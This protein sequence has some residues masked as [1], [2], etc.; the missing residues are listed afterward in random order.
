M[1]GRLLPV[2]ALLLFGAAVLLAVA[3]GGTTDES[4]LG[5]SATVYDEGP[6]GTALLRRYLEANGL[7]T[8]TLQSDRFVVPAEVDV[9]FLLGVTTDIPPQDI[10]T[11]REF[12]E[13]GGTLVIASDLAQTERPLLAA[14]DVRRAGGSAPPGEH[15]IHSIVFAA[16]VVRRLY[17]DVAGIVL[18]PGA[19]GAVLAG[20]PRA[21]L[22]V[23]VG[24]GRGRMYAVGSLAPFLNG[25]LPQ[26]DNGRLALS[27]AGITAG[28]RLVAFDEFHHGRRA[29]PSFA[30]VLTGSWP[31][32]A[33]LL[34]GA[35]AFA[36]LA[37]SGRRLGP[38]LPLD[39]RPPRSSLDYVRGFAGL[40]RRSGHGEIARRRIRSDLHQGLARRLGMD[41][42]TPFERVVAMLA[43]REPARA[44]RARS[45][46]IAL[47]RRMA[48]AE[49]VRSVGEVEDVVRGEP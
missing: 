36:Y 40:A 19:G 1:T 9:L 38:P 15:E 11:L 42:A 37:L 8:T 44:E 45:L 18:D 26:A 39:P 30:A 46:G 49:L 21:G 6:G 14:F 23:A 31:G 10:D 13:R 4:G 47:G 7:R 29:A 28:D 48:E 2:L 33:L 27:L 24:E 25:T 3:T 20:E 32:R 17:L 12:V 22:I 16:P 34:G 35:T 43:A 41:P 5:R